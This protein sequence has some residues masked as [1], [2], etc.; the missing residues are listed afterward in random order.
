MA[1]KSTRKRKIAANFALIIFTFIFAGI[2]CFNVLK[3]IE[4]KN[5]ERKPGT[6]DQVIVVEDPQKDPGVIDLQPTVNSWLQGVSGTAGIYIYDLDNETAVAE[7]NSDLTFGTASL[8]KLFVVYQ[9]YLNM[10]SGAS[11][12][13][14]I[15]TRGFT[16]LQCLDKAIRESHSGCAET[17]WSEMGRSQLDTIISQNWGI[18][19][20]QISR[21]ASTPKDMYKI[22]RKYYEHKDLTDD[23][24]ARIKDSMLVQ[25]PVN[26]GLCGGPCDWR[27][28]LPSGF[29]VASV[30]NKVG[31][32]HSGYGNIWNL[33]HDAAIVEFPATKTLKARHY[34]IIVMTKRITY[35]Q[36][37][38][39]G[40]AL[41][42]V[43][44]NN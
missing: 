16:R 5:K 1:A 10:Q 38:A 39:L 6:I 4:L 15:I 14:D 36:I 40:A 9:A 24:V 23:N 31:W 37:S 29:K 25:P 42:Q 18:T 8:Y 32:E 2:T 19:N 41:E 7:Y 34:I 43:I 21:L 17:L 26:N 27:R 11:G 33:Y 44:L 3:L 35:Q 20:S 28:G 12:P 13:N 22:M 30:Y